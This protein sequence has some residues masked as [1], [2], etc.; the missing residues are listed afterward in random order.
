LEALF[1]A[2]L[3]VGVAAVPQDVLARSR[4]AFRKYRSATIKAR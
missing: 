3:F 4:L 2:S 1:L